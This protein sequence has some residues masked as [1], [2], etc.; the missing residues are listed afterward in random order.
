MT[1]ITID[2]SFSPIDEA[3]IQALEQELGIQLPSDY[4]QFLLTHNGGR[5]TPA[6]F[7]LTGDPLN[8]SGGI[9]WFYG[10]HRGRERHYNLRKAYDVFQDRMP[11]NFFPIACDPGGN[12]IC[13]SVAGEDRETVYFWDHEFESL[14]DEKPGYE[15][16][17]FIANSFTELLNSLRE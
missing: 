1:H 16:V 14:D 8:S 4:R 12:Q 2:K 11:A 6:H 5:P 9:H 15:N 17:Y 13:L 3:T 7:P 10:I